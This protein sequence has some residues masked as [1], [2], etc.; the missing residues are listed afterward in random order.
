[1]SLM[2][3]SCGSTEELLKCKK[4]EISSN[5]FFDI[6]LSMPSL[7]KKASVDQYITSHQCTLRAEEEKP[8]NSAEHTNWFEEQSNQIIHTRD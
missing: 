5:I 1:M 2:C 7:P 4:Q 3:R 6:T 8:I